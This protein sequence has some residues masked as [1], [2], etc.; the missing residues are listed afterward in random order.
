MLRATSLALVMLVGCADH[1][2]EGMFIVNN[3]APSG[4]L[5]SLTGDP[6]QPFLAG[7]YISQ[8]SPV[9][10]FFTPL[11]ESRITATT[12]QTSQRTIHLEGANVVLSAAG[13]TGQ[14][15]T[16]SSYT[17]LFS[18]SVPPNDGTIN[19]GVE[20]VPLS[21]IQSFATSTTDTQLSANITTFGTLGGDKIE[22]EP[23]DYPITVCHD[24][25]IHSIAASCV[26]AAAA[27]NL[28]NPC[29]PFQ[30][31]I[32]DCCLNGTQLVCPTVV[33]MP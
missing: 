9:G 19:A 21:V 26:G 17:V 20:L 29:N 2:A 3:S 16:I 14:L 10:Y 4:T 28:G 18:G 11:I 15:T 27:L 8:L 24:C 1:G 30:D 23:F 32:V 5:C 13:T 12:S 22:A 7:G 31:G 6:I 33:A 25:I